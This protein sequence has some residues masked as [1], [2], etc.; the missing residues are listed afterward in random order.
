MNTDK[1][2][3]MTIRI[4]AAAL[5]GPQRAAGT[6]TFSH[7]TPQWRGPDRSECYDEKA[8]KTCANI[9]RRL[10]AMRVLLLV[11]VLLTWPGHRAS[12]ADVAAVA[13]PPVAVLEQGDLRVH[14]LLPDAEHGYY[15]D[16]RFDWSGLVG[17]V[18]WRGHTFFGGT[19]SKGPGYSLGTSDEYKDVLP[20]LG[21]PDGTNEIERIRIGVGVLTPLVVAAGKGNQV[22]WKLAE[23]FPWEIRRG[24]NFVEFSQIVTH[25][26]WGYELSKRIE[27]TTGADGFTIARRLKNTGEKTI[28]S[29]NYCHNWLRIDNE[30]VGSQYRLILP[31]QP[32]AEGGFRNRDKVSVEAVDDGYRLRF[33]RTLWAELG[34]R[35]EAR[36][37]A[38]RVV[39]TN[40]GASVQLTGDWVP[41]AFNL[42]AQ[43]G[44]VCP[45]PFLRLALPPGA[46]RDWKSSYRFAA[47]PQEK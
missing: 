26:P 8:L 47:K 4:L 12:R 19:G 43:P 10:S 36:D 15:R 31:F 35:T 9:N 29:M 5:A 40:T 1:L 2:M 34:A 13:P 20:V 41:D 46:Q 39:N 28:A 24:T 38:A 16:T 6:G 18:E 14:V 22:R 27:L 45:E 32:V 42:Y 7:S 30:Y 25:G 11:G 17:L 37:N 33:E 21:G 3:N 44:E 23:P